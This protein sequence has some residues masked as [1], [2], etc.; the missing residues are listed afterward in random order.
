MCSSQQKQKSRS[1]VNL[2]SSSLRRYISR[3]SL[4]HPSSSSPSPDTRHARQRNGDA[5]PQGDGMGHFCRQ[6]SAGSLRE[7]SIKGVRFTER[8]R[9]FRRPKGY[10]RSKSAEPYGRAPLDDDAST[11]VRDNSDSY[12]RSQSTPDRDCPDVEDASGG[13]EGQAHAEDGGTE[14]QL[15]SDLCAR[16]VTVNGVRPLPPQPEWKLRLPSRSTSQSSC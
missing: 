10:Q 12:L 8:S 1:L 16:N 14:T 7:M 13:G 6:Y 11:T 5:A 3:E 15:E 2:L 9:S 4:S